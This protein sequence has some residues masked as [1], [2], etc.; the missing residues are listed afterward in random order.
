RLCLHLFVKRPVPRPKVRLRQAG[1][2]KPH[3]LLAGSLL[4]AQRDRCKYLIRESV[5]TC[6]LAEFF[7]QIP[8]EFGMVT[9][10]RLEY[11]PVAMG[12]SPAPKLRCIREYEAM[13]FNAGRHVR[14]AEVF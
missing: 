14:E 11:S 9:G 3:K 13:R 5:R 2:L 1:L 8:F 7:E 10:E 4:G 12:P 6:P